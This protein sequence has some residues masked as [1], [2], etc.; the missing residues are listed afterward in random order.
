VIVGFLAGFLVFALI[1]GALLGYIGATEGLSD[2]G[3]ALLLGCGF[4]S[5]TVG[6][7]LIGSAV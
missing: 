3:A 4:V 2:I 1:F 6:G 7:A 5:F